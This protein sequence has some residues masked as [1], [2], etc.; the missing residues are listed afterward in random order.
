MIRH[1]DRIL[2]KAL[3]VF[4]GGL[5]STTALYWAA[6]HFDIVEGVSFDYGQRHKVELE[7]GFDGWELAR[8]LCGSISGRRVIPIEGLKAI[9]GSA[10]TTDELPHMDRPVSEMGEG[11]PNTY[12]P[13]R[14][15][16][17]LAYAAALAERIEADAIVGGWNVLDYSG[18]PDC[19]P[20]FLAA[21]ERAANEGRFGTEVA[22][23]APLLQLDKAGIIRLG[24]EHGARY[25]Y[26]ISCYM[27]K[28][29]P[30]GRCDSCILRAKGWA[31]VG[32]ADPIVERYGHRG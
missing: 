4:S 19:R 15:G 3:V 28:R 12:V 7:E 6:A 8:R 9:G 18:Y 30:C 17:M 24:L 11:Q 14:N 13:F 26:S 32:Q 5:D 21:M 20:S 10:L 22:I 29:N 27:G 16:I 31:E 2:K 23:L 25:D 1:K